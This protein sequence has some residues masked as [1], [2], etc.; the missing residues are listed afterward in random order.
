MSKNNYKMNFILPN[1]KEN[2]GWFKCADTSNFSDI[3]FETKEYI[4]SN[5]I[6]NPHALAVFIE[7]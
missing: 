5:Y 3:T 2:M 1:P 6:L 4:E 7:R